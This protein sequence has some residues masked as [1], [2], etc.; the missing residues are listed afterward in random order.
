M[1]I[2]YKS[3]DVNRD[4]QFLSIFSLGIV[5]A[6]K[7]NLITYDDAW[8]WLLNIRTL[9]V[10]ESKRLDKDIIEAIHLGTELGDVQRLIPHAFGKSCDEI[11]NLLKKNLME[12]PLK[13]EQIDCFL[14]I[15]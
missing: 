10:V 11:I 5:N 6:L 13:S 15:I 3:K 9:Q 4:N 8:N 2:I 7:E 1:E 12:N 14:E